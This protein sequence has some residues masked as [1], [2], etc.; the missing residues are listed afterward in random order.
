MIS[1]DSI[2]RIIIVAFA[3]YGILTLWFYGSIFASARA[4]LDIWYYLSQPNPA[5]LTDGVDYKPTLLA[6]IK[7]KLANLLTCRICLTPYLT[8]LLW[9]F[10]FEIVITLLAI[11]G[12][13]YFLTHLAER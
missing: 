3:V 2:Y 4:K 13:V 5:Q 12:E 11:A 10:P 8:I 1:S 9:F 7:G 6:R